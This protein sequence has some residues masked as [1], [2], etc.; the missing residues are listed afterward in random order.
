MADLERILFGFFGVA[1]GIAGTI[2]AAA[3]GAMTIDAI[4]WRVVAPWRRSSGILGSTVLTVFAL[5]LAAAG[6]MLLAGACGEQQ[7]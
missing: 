2:G 5:L 6:A 4:R 1:L 7:P 3:F